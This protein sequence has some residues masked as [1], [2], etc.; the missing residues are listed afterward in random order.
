MYVTRSNKT[1]RK[2]KAPSFDKILTGTATESDFQKKII[3]KG[4]H[5][6]TFQSDDKERY[7]R[8]PVWTT[9]PSGVRYNSH[10]DS[11]ITF[12]IPK[13]SGGY[14]EINAPNDS[15]RLKQTRINK[16][17]Q[18]VYGSCDHHAAAFAYYK[19]ANTISP[20]KKHQQNDSK[21][22][23]KLDIHDFF[24]S[25]TEDF[26]A[27]MMCLTK[28]FCNTTPASVK[29]YFS[30]CFKDGV[31]PQGGITSPILTN[32]I[33][34]PID[35]EISKYCRE[36]RIIYT[37]YADDMLF[38]CKSSF[39]W[40]ALQENVIEIFKMFDAPYVINKK[41]TRYGSK[42]GRNWNLGLMLNGKNEITIGHKTKKY[43]KSALTHICFEHDHMDES[44]RYQ[45][46][47]QI[48]YYKM[49]ETD[50]I[51]Y[52][53]QKYSQKFNF[54]I[55]AYLRRGDQHEFERISA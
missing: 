28:E 50:Y 53:I 40:T 11:Y 49:I 8:K 54:D 44:K 7:G 10:Q 31:L 5:T 4:P 34:I 18:R 3:R 12:R 15:L 21:W 43:L 24:G 46:A 38:S 47:G 1:Y 35:H 39:S 29:L 51:N 42:Y 48:A 22:F 33:M 16:Y 30:A 27:R 2:G 32:I 37:R 52:L 26:A 17:L 23:L 45:I 6:F 19:S 14:R 36:N 25:T 13:K 9:F 20:L 41:K 55:D